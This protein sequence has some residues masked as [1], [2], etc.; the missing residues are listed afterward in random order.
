MKKY[1]LRNVSTGIVNLPPEI[2]QTLGWNISD[3]VGIKTTE[4][5]GKPVIVIE[6]LRDVSEWR[7]EEG[8]EE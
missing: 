6:K 4:I 5:S 3:E 2:W 1:L 8:E 7:K